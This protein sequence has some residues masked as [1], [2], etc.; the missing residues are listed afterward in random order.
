MINWLS[1]IANG[2][3]VAGLS[4][5]LAALSYT[6]WLAGQ[7]GR[8]WGAELSQPGSL[9]VCLAGLFLVGLGLAG[10]SRSA[11]QVALAV[12]LLLGCVVALVSLRGAS[13]R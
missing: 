5:I 12:A 8:S 2:L 3:W 4:V 10:T 13:P 11:W 6:Y 7:A 1:V 9:R